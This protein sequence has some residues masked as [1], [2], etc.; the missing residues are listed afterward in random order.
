MP[1]AK[2]YGFIACVISLLL[3]IIFFYNVFVFNEFYL[4]I[5]LKDI[6]NL[7]FFTLAIP[8]GIVALLFLGTGFWVGWTIITIKAVQPMPEL[9]KKRDNSRIKAFFLCFIT[10]M[11]AVL[12][13]Y[14]IYKRSYWALA[15]PAAVVTLVILGMIFWVGIA[16]ITTRSTLPG[17]NE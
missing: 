7:T 5:N 8:I 17:K 11:I 12:F 3:G 15:I 10:L 1:R 9:V 13:L 16:I 4:N 2:V 14:G 6:S